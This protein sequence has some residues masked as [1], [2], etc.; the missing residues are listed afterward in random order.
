[1]SVK[2][3][4]PLKADKPKRPKLKTPT[5]S[6]LEDACGMTPEEYEAFHRQQRESVRRRWGLTS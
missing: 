1:M 4:S 2:A 6:I 3:D 5:K